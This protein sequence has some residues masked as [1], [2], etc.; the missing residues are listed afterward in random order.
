M[1]N[2]TPPLPVVRPCQLR[3]VARSSASYQP[4]PV[5][6][7]ALA[8]RRRIDALHLQYPFA[9]ARLLGD[10]LRHEGHAL[11]RRQV[12]TRLRRMGLEA[13]ARTPRLSPRHPAHTIYA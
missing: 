12:A 7:P 4:R 8:R 10:C 3:G 6:D 5:A 11:G 13:G 9:G 2:P 1:L